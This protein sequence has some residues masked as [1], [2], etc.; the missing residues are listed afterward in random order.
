[1][2]T[3]LASGDVVFSATGVTK[4]RCWKA[5]MCTRPMSRRIPIV[6]RSATK[7]RALDQDAPPDRQ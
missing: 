5:C 2:L 7:D 1:M 3:D 4:A 6:M